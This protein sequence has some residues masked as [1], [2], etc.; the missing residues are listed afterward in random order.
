MRRV[1]ILSP[2][3]AQVAA[4][5]AIM[6]TLPTDGTAI[7]YPAIALAAGEDAG[8]LVEK[9]IQDGIIATDEIDHCMRY[10]RIGNC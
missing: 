5:A 6:A 8:R 3:T 1:D 4:I 2:G 9:L 10:R 7:A